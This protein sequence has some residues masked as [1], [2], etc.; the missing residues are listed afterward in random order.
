MEEVELK[1]DKK[2]ISSFSSFFTK[3]ERLCGVG[4]K[5]NMLARFEEDKGF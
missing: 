2:E 1:G 4:N 3:K 5:P